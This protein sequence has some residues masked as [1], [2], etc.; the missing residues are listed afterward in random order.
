MQ[1][2]VIE[3]KLERIEQLLSAQ[4]WQSKPIFNI[5]EV[6]TYTGLS[7]FYIYKL[8]SKNL[9]PHYKPNGKNLFFKKEEIDNWLLRNKQSSKDEIDREAVDFVVNKLKK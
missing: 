5:D 4:A 1:Q 7:K 6:A 8:S 9:I 3:S 2:N